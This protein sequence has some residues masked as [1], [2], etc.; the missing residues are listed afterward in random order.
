MELGVYRLFSVFSVP[1]FRDAVR[2]NGWDHVKLTSIVQHCI[3]L[4]FSLPSNNFLRLLLRT[5]VSII[6]VCRSQMF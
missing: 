3:F 1:K 5:T 4:F 6:R 2:V